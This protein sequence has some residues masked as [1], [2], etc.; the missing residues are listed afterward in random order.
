MGDTERFE[1]SEPQD[2]FRTEGGRKSMEAWL[3]GA[4]KRNTRGSRQRV[5][6]EKASEVG[7]SWGQASVGTLYPA[8]CDL[9]LP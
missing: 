6:G 5:T 8:L 1:D 3:R 4:Q 2:R 9:F 7:W